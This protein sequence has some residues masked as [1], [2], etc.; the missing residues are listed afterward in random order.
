MTGNVIA[1]AIGKGN[2]VTTGDVNVGLNQATNVPPDLLAALTAALKGIQ[3]SDLSPGAKKKAEE[4]HAELVKELNK[5][6]GEENF[7]ASC[8]AGLWAVAQKVPAV[9]S[10]WEALKKH[11]PGIS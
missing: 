2:T 3:A 10:L 1:S 4:Q 11:V 5:S 6:K 8:W 7:V 9:V